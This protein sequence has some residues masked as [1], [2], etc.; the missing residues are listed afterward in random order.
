[1]KQGA[2]IRGGRVNKERIEVYAQHKMYTF[3][4]T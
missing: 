4:K 3:M 2:L 1:M